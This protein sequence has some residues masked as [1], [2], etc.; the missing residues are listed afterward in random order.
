MIQRVLRRLIGLPPRRCRSELETEWVELRDG[1]RLATHHR[2][3]IDVQDAPTVL[4]RTPYGVRGGLGVMEG[5]TK[6]IAESGY[7][8][9]SQDVR[10]R[11]ESEG[12]F[13]PFVAEREDGADTLDWLVAQPWCDGRIG[14]FGASYLAYTAWAALAERPEHVGAMALSIG[15]GDLYSTFYRGGAFS[16][17]NALEWAAGVGER[18]NVPPREVDIERGFAFRPVR[19][20]DRV[21]RRRVDWYREWADHPTDDAFWQALNPPRPDDVPPTLLLA[22]FWDFFLAPELA[23]WRAIATAKPETHRLVIGPWAH[24]LVARWR[25]WRH[26]P[27][28]TALRESIAHFDVHLRHAAD[29]RAERRVRYFVSGPDAWRDAD[30]WPP[31]DAGIHTLNLRNVEG[32]GRLEFDAGDDEPLEI[33]SDPRTPVPT[34]GGAMFGLKSGAKDHSKVVRRSDVLTYDSAPLDAPLLALGRARVEIEA[35]VDSEDADFCAKL[36]DVDADGRAFNVCDGIVRARWRSMSRSALEP[37]FLVPNEVARFEIDLGEIATCFEAGHVVRL[38]IAGSNAPRYDMNPGD[39]RVPAA[40]DA[41]SARATRQSVRHTS[42]RPSR[43]ILGG[44]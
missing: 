10:G 42:Q 34:L 6:L 28:S 18:E 29:T 21:A 16:F 30:H 27:V 35:S 43:L 41:E 2:W 39:T 9:V 8:C 36:L 12:T 24:G 3:P 14:L 26:D 40:T 33:T 19:E 22:G 44:A 13:E 11:Y 38:Q 7:H 5:I 1:T 4:I 32:R 37:Q 25:W 15:S 23:D 20:A 17:A 31:E